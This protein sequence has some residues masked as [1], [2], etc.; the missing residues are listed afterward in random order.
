[1]SRAMIVLSQ[2]GLSVPEHAERLGNAQF[3]IGENSEY[4]AIID[5]SEVSERGGRVTVIVTTP[6]NLSEAGRLSERLLRGVTL[7]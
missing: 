5:C 2:A 6:V 4:T 3:S 1:M 7:H